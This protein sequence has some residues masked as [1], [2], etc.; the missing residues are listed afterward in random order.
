M[1]QLTSRKILVLLISVFLLL[2]PT[3]I[4]AQGDL[5][6]SGSPPIEQPLVR[7]GAFAVKLSSALGL[8]TTDNETEAVNRLSSVGIAPRNGWIADYPVTPDII[9]ELQQSV[10]DAADAKSI[11]M[12]RYEAL[13]RFADVTAESDLRC[14]LMLPVLM[15]KT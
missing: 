5:V 2:I 12:D 4:H 10:G 7:E 14:N 15:T 1:K 3:M 6:L 11:S 9:G 8:G 13:E